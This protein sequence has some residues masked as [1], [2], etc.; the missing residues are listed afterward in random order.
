MSYVD[1]STHHDNGRIWVIW[2]NNNIQI[3]VNKCTNQL[4]HCQI[5]NYDGSFETL[6][7]TIY[8]LNKLDQRRV[9]WSSIEDIHK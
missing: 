3:N 7:T 2:D 9:M 6:L 1:N 4:I 8:A 5:C